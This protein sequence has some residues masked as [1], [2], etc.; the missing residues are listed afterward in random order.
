VQ[1]PL[2]LTNTRGAGLAGQLRLRP[3]SLIVDVTLISH[4]LGAG[5][6]LAAGEIGKR[7]LV[8]DQRPDGQRAGVQ[9]HMFAA[10]APVLRR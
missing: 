6:H 7:R 2:V 1:F 3:T 9:H 5:L 4:Q 8:A 10:P